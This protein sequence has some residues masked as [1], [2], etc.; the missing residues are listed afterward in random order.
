MRCQV[1]SLIRDF[2][3][4]VT[5]F[6]LVFVVQN[7][8]AKCGLLAFSTGLLRCLCHI[9]LQLSYGVL[10]CGPRVIH[11]VDDEHIFPYQIRHLQTAEVEPLCAGDLC[12]WLLDRICT[13]GFVEGETDG[14]DR[15]VRAAGLLQERPVIRQIRRRN[16]SAWERI[17]NRRIRA[18]T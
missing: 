13:E 11:L 17:A 2:L 5:L 18:G 8:Y 7:E 9:F 10:Q 12:A 6:R 14:L 3:R 4:K 1:F 16:P 15:D